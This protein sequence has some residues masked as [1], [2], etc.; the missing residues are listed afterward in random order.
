MAIRLKGTLDTVAGATTGSYIRIEYVKYMPWIGAVEYNPICFKNELEADMSRIRY[1]G[2]EL[3]SATYPIPNVSMSLSSGSFTA[4][5]NIENIITLPLTSSLQDVNISHYGTAIMSASIEVSDFDENGDEIITEEVIQWQEHS[6]ISQSV[7]EK[8]P[9][10][11]SRTGSILSQCYQH[12]K[13]TLAEQIPA[14][15]ILD[16]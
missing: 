10:D 3:P 9:I 4:D 2:D 14:E 13:D 15:N 11:L 6:I 8:Y 1:F 16:V 5:V 12:L 7:E